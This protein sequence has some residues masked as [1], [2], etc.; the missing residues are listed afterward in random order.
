MIERVY[1]C[2]R[3]SG[4]RRVVVATDDARIN[5]A[6]RG[7]GGEA[8]MTAADHRSGTARI[9][10]A[11]AILGIDPDEVVGNLQGD[12]PLMPPALM[13]QVADTLLAH[14]QASMATA[15]HAIHDRRVFLD[16][17][18]V[19]LVTDRSGFALYFSR[20]PIPWP[21]DETAR[22]GEF[23]VDALRHIGIYAYRAEF[24]SRY[25][26]WSPCPPERT[27]SLEQ[28]RVLWNG[29][30]IAVCETPDAPAGGV[31]TAE[32]LERVRAA[33]GRGR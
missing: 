1:A 5:A 29:E 30:R 24:V 32:D 26:D 6:V 10:E 20:A 22:S 27:E 2:A 3:A 13:R 19:K 7:F 33:F 9:A 8:C 18:V 28:L 4:A 31:D 23:P 25:A 12:E 15:C 16:P 21:R 17:N 11:I 14:P